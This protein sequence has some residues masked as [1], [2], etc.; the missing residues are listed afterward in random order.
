MRAR[1]CIVRRNGRGKTATRYLV[2]GGAGEKG[3]CR[4]IIES[5][6]RKIGNARRDSGV[7]VEEFLPNARRHGEEGYR[8]NITNIRT[9]YSDGPG[10]M[11]RRETRDRCDGC[12]I[13]L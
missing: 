7:F 1:V 3:L 6:E 5:M 8:I 13:A 9:V 10:P 4:N 11:R 2:D 12:L